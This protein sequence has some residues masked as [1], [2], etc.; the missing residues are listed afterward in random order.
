MT[1]VKIQ[2]E[3]WV[4]ESILLDALTGLF[5]D[6]YLTSFNTINTEL[7]ASDYKVPVQDVEQAL[8]NING[9]IDIIK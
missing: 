3:V 6:E 8:R 2:D 1:C 4:L 5:K 9:Y 7:L